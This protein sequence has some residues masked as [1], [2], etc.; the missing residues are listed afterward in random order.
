MKKRLVRISFVVASTLAVLTAAKCGSKGYVTSPVPGVGQEVPL[1]QVDGK[2]VPTVIASGVSSQTT[3]VGGKATLGE[4][5]ASG[6]YNVVLQSES[7][8][9]AT[10]ATITGD[11]IFTWTEKTVSAP[12]DLGPGLGTHTFTFQRN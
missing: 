8:G 7:G 2:A 4:A 3:V 11:V 6:R 12:I 5:I 10:N 1:V 9:S